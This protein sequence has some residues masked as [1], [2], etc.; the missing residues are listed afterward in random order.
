MSWRCARCACVD[1]CLAELNE[2]F[3]KDFRAPADVFPG[4]LVEAAA[5]KR[6]AVAWV[7]RRYEGLGSK[8]RGA[9]AGAG[10]SVDGNEG[11]GDDEDEDDEDDEAPMAARM[12]RLTRKA[13]ERAYTSSEWAAAAA[14]AAGED[15]ED[16][17]SDSDDESSGEG[18]R[19]DDEEGGEGGDSGLEEGAEGD[20]AVYNE[21]SPRR[22]R[23]R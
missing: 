9:S 22:L 14:L 10:A 1:M 7:Q 15:G 16:S 23:E 5:F 20:A 13:R 21:P 18:S 6:E 3:D 8:K 17:D 11:E 2:T 12:G 19:D 4:A